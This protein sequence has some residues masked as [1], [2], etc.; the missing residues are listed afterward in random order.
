LG[1][2]FGGSFF[3]LHAGK[4]VYTGGVLNVNLK[5]FTMSVFHYEQQPYGCRTIQVEKYEPVTA[6]EDDHA[7]VRNRAADGW[8]RI[9]GTVVAGRKVGSLFHGVP[10]TVHDPV[11]EEVTVEVPA[12]AWEQGSYVFYSC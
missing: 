5:G 7:Y 12:Y 3:C 10:V 2:P 9:Y 8:V 11:G 1:P 4:L 6:T